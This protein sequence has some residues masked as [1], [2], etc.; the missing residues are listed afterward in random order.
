M[1][2]T[3]DNADNKAMMPTMDNYAVTSTT[4]NNANEDTAADVNAA[5]QMTR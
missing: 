5:M 2:T 4:G 3:D 1:Q